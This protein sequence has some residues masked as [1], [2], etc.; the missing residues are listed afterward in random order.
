M[1]SQSSL[2]EWRMI[3]DNVCVRRGCVVVNIP[4]PTQGG[5][6]ERQLTNCAEHLWQ[7]MTA[8]VHLRELTVC[9]Y[10]CVWVCVI[11]FLISSPTAIKP[12]WSMQLPLPAFAQPIKVTKYLNCTDERCLVNILWLLRSPVYQTNFGSGWTECAT[13]NLRFCFVRNQ[14]RGCLEGYI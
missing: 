4:Q 12:S 11:V 3:R 10:V 8:P 2:W 9:V 14:L 1:S 13:G 7:T 5:Q 6:E